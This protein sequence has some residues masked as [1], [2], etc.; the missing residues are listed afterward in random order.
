MLCPALPLG[1]PATQVETTLVRRTCAG[2]T[3]QKNSDPCCTKDQVNLQKASSQLGQKL[4]GQVEEWVMGN[5]IWSVTVQLE[6][7]SLTCSSDLCGLHLSNGS[8]AALEVRPRS[9]VGYL[10]LILN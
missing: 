4:E 5:K 10:D 3:S 6:G 7:I 1:T 2:Y 8:L 9:D